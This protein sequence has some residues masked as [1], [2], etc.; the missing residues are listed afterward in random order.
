ME[1]T[2]K[3]V[4][5]LGLFIKTTQTT[6]LKKKKDDEEEKTASLMQMEPLV[7]K[8]GAQNLISWSWQ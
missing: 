6:V 1:T 3:D 2:S 5:G 4:Q 8:E 7:P